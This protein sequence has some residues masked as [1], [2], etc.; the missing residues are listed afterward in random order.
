MRDEEL[1]G[2][3]TSGVPE[4]VATPAMSIMPLH[5]VRHCVDSAPQ[6]RHPHGLER[7]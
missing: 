7:A 6:S 1:V 5:C 4:E 3:V 2:A